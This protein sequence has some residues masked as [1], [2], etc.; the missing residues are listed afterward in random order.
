MAVVDFHDTSFSFYKN[1]MY[2]NHVML[3]GQLKPV[4]EE[5]FTPVHNRVY[6]SY[7]LGIWEWMQFVGKK[8]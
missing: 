2:G 1:F 8:G 4:L 5:H 7:L 3:E 6:K